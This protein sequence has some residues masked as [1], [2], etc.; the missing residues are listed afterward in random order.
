[1]AFLI[2]LI[3]KWEGPNKLTVWSATQTPSQPGFVMQPQMGFHNVRSTGLHCGSSYGPKNL[4][5]HPLSYAA[6]LAKETNKPVKV[7]YSKEEHMGAFVLRLGSRIRS[8]IGIKKD[9]PVT[10][11]SGD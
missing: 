10:A 2:G 4:Y 9:G 8:K 6:A 11:I 7:M 3:V 5:A 1:M